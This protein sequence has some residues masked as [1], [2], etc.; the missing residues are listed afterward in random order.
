MLFLFRT[1]PFLYC[2]QFGLDIIVCIVNSTITSHPV[3][4]RDGLTRY[5]HCGV[6][7]D[8]VNVDSSFCSLLKKN[9][10]IFGLQSSYFYFHVYGSY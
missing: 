5:T 2:L 4:Q 8:L 1:I 6:S 3:K 9:T 7:S 10:Y